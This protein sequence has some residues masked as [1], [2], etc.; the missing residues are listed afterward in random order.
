MHW[1]RLLRMMKTKIEEEIERAVKSLAA[2]SR[3][4]LRALLSEIFK[5]H[6]NLEE[7]KK[8]SHPLTEES[9]KRVEEEDDE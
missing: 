4:D 3:N 2:T 1:E 5:I 7:W 6:M 9:F 8:Q